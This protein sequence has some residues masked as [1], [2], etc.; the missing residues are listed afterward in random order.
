MEKAIFL[1]RDGVINFERGEYTFLMEDF[2]IND[3]VTKALSS[4][5][6]R[7]YQ[8]FI[9]TNQSGISKGLYTHDHVK[10]IH[11]FLVSKLKESEINIH[12]IYYCPHHPDI[13]HCLC[14]KPNS[15][16]VEKAIARFNI[17]PQTSFFIG[18]KERDV[19]AG[20]SA[21]LT[22]ILIEPNSSLLELLSVIP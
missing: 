10:K 7:G 4:F 5:Q 14:R 9:T 18:D 12:A 19:V 6:S 22:G 1:D 16:L 17:D 3:G 8:L 15:L 20:G 11:D 2:K 21:G 13:G